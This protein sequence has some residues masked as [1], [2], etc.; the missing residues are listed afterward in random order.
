MLFLIQ[1]RQFRH[2]YS[3]LETTIDQSKS[4]I[5]DDRKPVS[6]WTNIV[7][8][9]IIHHSCTLSFTEI[10]LFFADI[11]IHAKASS[12]QVNVMSVMIMSDNV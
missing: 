9:L 5:T 1:C 10:I 6:K 3:H 2:L 7:P 11:T 12:V 4:K 8:D